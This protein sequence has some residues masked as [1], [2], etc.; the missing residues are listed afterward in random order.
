MNTHDIRE[1]LIIL[2]MLMMSFMAM[3]VDKFSNLTKYC[4][5]L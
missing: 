3:N 2:L 1:I 5:M 4:E